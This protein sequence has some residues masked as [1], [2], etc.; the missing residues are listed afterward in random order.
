[1]NFLADP[2]R[3]KGFRWTDRDSLTWTAAAGAVHSDERVPTTQWALEV[4][5]AWSDYLDA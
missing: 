5:W 3:S 2:A 1:M 4:V